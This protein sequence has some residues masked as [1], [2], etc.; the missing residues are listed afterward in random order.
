M[1]TV[2]ITGATAGIGFETAKQ[3]AT[4]GFRVIHLSRNEEKSKK[5]NKLI[6]NATG[7]TN[8]SHVI[9]DLADL[10]S[11][12]RAAA[13]V[14]EKTRRIDVLINNAGG[15]VDTDERSADGME[16]HFAINHLGHFHLTTLLM[17]E[18]LA[19]KARVIN[20]TSEAHRIGYFN[21]KEIKKKKGF[22][23]GFK[24]Y[25]DAK[26]CNLLFTLELHKRY[27]ERGLTSY[28]VHPGVVNTSFGNNMKGLLG[29]M[30]KFAQLFM[31][32]PAKGAA[33]TVYLAT[34]ENVEK[35]S[36]GYFKRRRLTTPSSQATN[37]S[38]AGKLWQ[39]SEELI[40]EALG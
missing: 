11:V 34:S 8:V 21:A 27:L 5:V 20:V 13:A 14:K 28:S 37:E 17:N 30:I 6:E 38:N 39:L 25:G 1:N 23:K 3:L 35:D 12:E 15:V 4:K 7:N 32:T 19:S 36:G 22:Q 31:I 16:M 10:R 29:G 2:V 18:L 24:G 33:T 40:A 9:C 26:L